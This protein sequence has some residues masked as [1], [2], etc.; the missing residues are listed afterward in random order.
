MSSDTVKQCVEL[1]EKH[2]HLKIV[3]DIVGIPWQ[4]VYV[5]LKKEGVAVT[6]DKSMYGGYTDR[7]AAKSE[8]DFLELVPF[9]EDMNRKKFQSKYDFDVLGFK[10]DLK[11]STLKA[12]SKACKVKRYSFSVKKQE[13]DADFFVC[14]GYEGGKIQKAY[15][16]PG[17]LVR[18]MSSISISEQGGKWSSY[19]I[20]LKEIPNFFKQMKRAA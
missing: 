14:F 6:G 4:T 18:H 10:V 7:F 8:K 9:A 11:A 20:D 19:E 12:S 13:V 1:Y 15:L 2:K 16:I 17:E 3:G 5:H